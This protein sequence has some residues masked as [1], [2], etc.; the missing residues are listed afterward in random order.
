MCWERSTIAVTGGVTKVAEII[1]RIAGI[2]NR[3]VV[4]I[5][6][7]GA[8]LGAAVA[9]ASA[10]AKEKGREF[11]ADALSAAV[12]PRSAPVEPRPGDVQAYHGDGCYLAKLLPEFE[13]RR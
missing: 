7:V 4:T 3:P 2:W 12:L 6:T 9:G 5:G 1:R 8:A 10:L 13:K 11:N